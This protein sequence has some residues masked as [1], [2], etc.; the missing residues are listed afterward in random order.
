MGTQV[1]ASSMR[2]GVLL[3]VAC[4]VVACDAYQAAPD[5]AANLDAA[6]APAQPQKSLPIKFHTLAGLHR[7]DL[8]DENADDETYRAFQLARY[9]GDAMMQVKQHEQEFMRK[10]REEMR[11][12][13]TDLG[14]SNDVKAAPAPKLSRE[15]EIMGDHSSEVLLQVGEGDEKSAVPFDAVHVPRSG[16]IE[17][18]DAH[19]VMTDKLRHKELKHAVLGDSETAEENE[20][21]KLAKNGIRAPTK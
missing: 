11:M 7:I 2:W 9:T 14:Q 19:F 5:Y 20:T 10:R 4:V 12:S 1:I 15:E 21:G 6:G 18:S 13:E 16:D 8:D 17:D 3:A